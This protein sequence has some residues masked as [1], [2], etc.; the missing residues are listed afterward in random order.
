VC[1]KRTKLLVHY[2]TFRFMPS[3]RYVEI[4]I[5]AKKHS[6][7]IMLK[8]MASNSGR[9]AS[10]NVSKYLCGSPQN[11]HAN[12]AILLSCTPPQFAPNLITHLL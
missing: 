6:L 1:E 11:L 2:I 3:S 12:F 5:N 4:K 10:H 8:V 9:T 7:F